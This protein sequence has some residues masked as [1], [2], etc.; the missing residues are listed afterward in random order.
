MAEERPRFRRDLVARPI[1]ADGVAYVEAVDPRTGVAFRFYAVEHAVAEA[2]DGRT[3]TEIIT[4]ARERSGLP[5]TI[6][7]LK[8]FAQQLTTLGFMESGQDENRTREMPVF[9]GAI[10]A[11]SRDAPEPAQAPSV[12]PPVP[13]ARATDDAP[14]LPASPAAP[15][16]ATPAEKDE[17][18]PAEDLDVQ[19]RTG[20]SLEALSASD[21]QVRSPDE[22][23]ELARTP[24][25]P[26]AVPGIATTTALAA[27][28]GAGSPTLATQDRGSPSPEAVIVVD[29]L[30]GFPPPSDPTAPR[31]DA[32]SLFGRAPRPVNDKVATRGDADAHPPPIGTPQKPLTEETAM[33]PVLPLGPGTASE[34]FAAPANGK[35]AAVGGP[36]RPIPRRPSI[37]ATIPRSVEATIPQSIEAT[38]PDATAATSGVA[39][40][41]ARAAP[42]P[43]SQPSMRSGRTF[44]P[45]AYAGLGLVT[46]AIVVFIFYHSVTSNTEPAPLVVRTVVPPIG[47]VYR[48][49]DSVGTVKPGGERAL[50]FASAGKVASVLAPGSVFQPGGV[51]AELEG[52]RRW[53]SELTH[54]NER[55]AH[56]EKMLAAAR[57]KG[58]ASETRQAE[59]KVAEKKRLLAEAQAKLTREQIIAAGPG[60]IAEKLVAVGAVVKPGATAA[61]TKGTDWRAELELSHDEAERLRHLGFCHVEIDGKPLDCNLAAEGG[62]DTHVTI[63]LAPDPA[64]TAGKP[65][66][67]ARARFD[68]VFVLPASALV[69]SKGSDHR[70]FVA[71]DGH[72][73]P[74]AVIIADQTSTDIVV[75]Q[76]LEP[77]SA[78]ILDP[79]PALNPRA[80]IS[81]TE[82]R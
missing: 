3:L 25:E 62:D 49:F 14:A 69:P 29:T 68:G 75:S 76:G 23:D 73:E 38:I 77:G 39:P 61:R 2:F 18:A 46:A 33:P 21:A 81:P 4:G 51:I 7:Q 65:V 16:H 57:A 41:P 66:R 54:H 43:E 24:D 45:A 30:S 32:P 52:A 60:E 1:E 42:A 40:P 6:E 28:T 31:Q 59:T 5:L 20:S 35:P 80:A 53:K 34:P 74:T 10:A 48:W 8:Q 22:D 44:S 13:V 26:R 63:D 27:R 70:V 64:V 72:A 71:K 36:E 11:T 15:P 37:E 19:T 50:I 12:V 56:Y 82:T 67:V 78:V 17:P 47:S 9:P 55:L 58:D 79:P